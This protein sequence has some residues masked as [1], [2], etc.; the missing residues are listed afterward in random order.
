MTTPIA[1]ARNAT[2]A[3]RRASPW[4]ALTACLIGVFMQMLDLTVVNTALPNLARD[5]PASGSQQ[6]AV[7][8]G[9]SLAFACALLTAAHLGEI[10]GRRTV[11]LVATVVFVA[12]SIWCGCAS[13]A[14]TLVAGRVVQ[15]L[16]AAGMA[17]Q[18]VAIVNACFAPERRV[19]VFGIHGAV[20][21]LAGLA[22][23]LVGGVIIAANPFGLGWHA[24]FLLNVPMG[25]AGFAL[26][27]RCLHLGAAARAARFDLLGVLLSSAGLLSILYP[28]T[29][30]REK[31]WPALL[32]VAITAGVAMLAWFGWRL[33]R[34]TAGSGLLRAEI[35]GDRGFVVG[36]T[37]MLVFYGLF[38]A[39]LFTVSVAAQSGLGMTALQTAGLMAPFVLGAVPAALTAPMLVARIGTRALTAGIVLFGLSLGLIASSLHPAQAGIDRNLL[40]GP[41][42]LAGAG[43]GWFAAPLPALITDRV[44][45]AIKD[46]ASG[47]LPT[48][49]QLGSAVG[50]ACLG[51]LF[52]TLVGS[53]AGVDQGKAVLA[54]TLTGV[55]GGART[56]VVDRFGECAHAV[57]A[58][59]TPVLDAYTCPTT[60]PAPAAASIAMAHSYLAAGVTLLWTVS[61]IALGVGALTLAM[62]RG[63]GSQR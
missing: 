8:A 46:S 52:F 35:F 54:R 14:A 58:S 26:A 33:G 63:L 25:A 49:Q 31:G 48:I 61:G 43:M 34:K 41:V 24:I 51:S 17:A 32:F 12:A 47:L 30:G 56:D 39:F 9:Y 13:E 23:P 21:G 62:P 36:A 28:V 38:T 55:S 29:V 11:F 15:G 53:G 18:T 4:G 50:S 19:L 5:L 16:G 60:P 2:R 40:S 59:A 20:A 42:F 57:L 44:S 3:G 45:A 1:L 27:Y 22:G 6:L 10:H 37:A 7:V